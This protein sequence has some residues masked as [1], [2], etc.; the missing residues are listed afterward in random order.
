MQHILVVDDEPSIR[1]VLQAHLS[2]EGYE[3]TVAQDGADAIRQLEE[4]DFQL[5]I[6][7]LKMPKVG[8][9]EL[10]AYLRT[11]QPA[12]PMIIVTAHATIDAAVDAL[13]L[14]AQDFISK[15]FD[16]AELRSS[17]EKALRTERARR[18]SSLTDPGWSQS[19]QKNHELIGCTPA[20]QR[21]YQLL[22][23][24]ADSPTTV[25]ITGES[26]T[27]KELAARALHTRSS[28][29]DRPFIAINCGA[30]PENLFESELFGY[31]KG[32]FTGAAT[33][34]PGRFELAD[35]GT[36]FLDEVGELPKEMQVKLLRA[37][38]ER[39]VERV[40]GLRPIAVDV[41]VVAATNVDLAAAV[42]AGR[43]REDLYYRLNVIA[44]RLPPLRERKEDIPLLI[45][46]FMGRYN[47]RLGKQ[48]TEVSKN[49]LERLGQWS[50]PGN[51]REL[52]NVV[53]RG[54]LL[55][56][57]NALE[58]DLPED[59]PEEDTPDPLSGDI[60]LKDWIQKETARMERRKIQ[61]VLELESGNVTRAARRLRISRKGL[62]LKMKEYNLREDTEKE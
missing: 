60:D 28:R 37:L 51:I 36:L 16:L 34:K 13:K 31:E 4:Q 10:L 54:I 61:Q 45:Q 38:Q 33:A 14:G 15:P 3:V 2:R 47:Q 55:A 39:M 6:S 17:V 35:G 8:G 43:F 57:G 1:K 48:V 12:V 40:G 19:P 11:H 21:V 25:L 41:R 49:T 29:R 50:W 30:I 23:K 27:G 20:M 7:D 5:V 62:Q 22:D 53:E 58:V 52:E 42:A 44:I 59:L 18:R 56:E 9:L 26:G 24:V 46:H 32:A